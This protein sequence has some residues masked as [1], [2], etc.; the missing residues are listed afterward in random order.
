MH[1]PG[2]YVD[3][4]VSFSS[5]FQRKTPRIGFPF[6]F[7]FA[8]LKVLYV[9]NLSSKYLVYEFDIS[10]FVV[11]E[12]LTVIRMILPGLLPAPAYFFLDQCRCADWKSNFP[13][14]FSINFLVGKFMIFEFIFHFARSRFL[15]RFLSLPAH[16]F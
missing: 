6:R 14:V 12:F 9:L 2:R 7:G 16:D 11:P 15:S 5:L 3:F 1:F 4:R 8:Q 10:E 13:G